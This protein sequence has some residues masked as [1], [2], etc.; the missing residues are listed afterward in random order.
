MKSVQDT[1]RRLQNESLDYIDLI[2]PIISPTEEYPIHVSIKYQGD[3]FDFLI[4]ETYPL[5]LNTSTL[6]IN[7]VEIRLNNLLWSPV[8]KLQDLV[9]EWCNN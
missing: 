1:L 5:Y 9:L 6:K 7:G 2:V 8:N 3:H 4:G